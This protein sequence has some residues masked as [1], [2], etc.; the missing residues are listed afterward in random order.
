MMKMHHPFIIK[1]F[2]TYQDE[3]LVYMLLELVQ[4]GE[5]FSVMHPG[6]EFCWLPEAQVKFYAIAIADAL[7]YMHRGKYVFRDLK[8]ENVMI[9]RFG[10]PV[11][12]DFGFAKYVPEKTYT[13]CGSKFGCAIIVL[14]CRVV[15]LAPYW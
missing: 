13:L 2:Q 11:V 8:P 12:I 9:D 15:L 4:G 3:N 7:A 1:L 10:Y 14:F 6:S 5:L